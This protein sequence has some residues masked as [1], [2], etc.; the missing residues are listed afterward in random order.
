MRGLLLGCALVLVIAAA[1]GTAGAAA[2]ASP[3]SAPLALFA[4]VPAGGYPNAFPFGQCTW[5]VAFN[6][7][8]S[9]N[10]NAADWLANATAQGVPTA[11]SPSVGAIAAFRPGGPY[12]E[13]GHVAVVVAVTDRTY[14]VSEMNAIGWGRISTRLLPWPDPYAAGFIPLTAT[15]R[16]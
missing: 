2:L 15:E 1:G 10:G 6:R 3:A 4:V 11:P 13:L 5:W 9:W 16:P 7:R 12:S 8:V 14:T